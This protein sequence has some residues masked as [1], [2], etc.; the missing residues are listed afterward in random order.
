LNRNNTR[1]MYAEFLRHGGLLRIAV[2]GLRLNGGDMEGM[3]R[4]LSR[5]DISGRTDNR[6]ASRL[7][8]HLLQTTTAR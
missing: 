8:G 4:S 1:E 3:D 5:S 6:A 2:S 7:I